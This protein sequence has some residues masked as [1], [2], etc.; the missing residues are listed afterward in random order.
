MEKNKAFAYSVPI[1]AYNY[2][3]CALGQGYNIKLDLKLIFT[4]T[5]F[6]SK[7]NISNYFFDDCDQTSQYK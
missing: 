4:L 2:L 5:T 6:S 7:L 3:Q 1:G